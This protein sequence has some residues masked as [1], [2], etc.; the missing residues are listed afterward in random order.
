MLVGDINVIAIESDIT[1][2]YNS[3]G[4]RGLGFFVV[5]VSGKRY[6][7]YSPDATLLACSFYEVSNRI[8]R[9]RQHVVPFD[10]DEDALSIAEAYLR[11]TYYDDQDEGNP[12]RLTC[13]QLQSALSIARAVW[14]PDGDEAFDDGSHILHFDQSENVRLIAFKNS[15]DKSEVAASLSDVTLAANTFYSVLCEWRDRFEADWMARIKLV[16]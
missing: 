5:Y 10:D 16:N 4:Q 11:C 2:A 8:S 14:A 1:H 15:Q 3:L 13:P 12:F 7:V 9:R 6:G